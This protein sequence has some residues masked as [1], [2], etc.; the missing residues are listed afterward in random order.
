[1]AISYCTKLLTFKFCV[2]KNVSFKKIS[3]LGLVL[4]GASAVTAAMLPGKA[5]VKVE[6]ADDGTLTNNLQ[7]TTNTNLTCVADDTGVIVSCNVSATITTG[8]GNSFVDLDGNGTDQTE[9]NTSVTD[10]NQ[11]SSFVD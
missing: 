11:Q 2:M 4:M 6:D 8:V 10:G 1:M 5:S 3:I 7:S 9:G